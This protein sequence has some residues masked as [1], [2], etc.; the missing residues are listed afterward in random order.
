MC[1]FIYTAALLL[2]TTAA[3]AQSERGQLRVQVQDSTGAAVPAAI[4]L[5]SDVNHIERTGVAN[6]SGEFTSHNLPFGI[7]RLTVSHSGFAAA[8]RLIEIHSEPVMSVA[9]TLGVAPVTSAVVVND[10]ATLVDPSRTSTTYTVGRQAVNQSL[11]AQPG[12][13]LTDL[14]NDQPGW[15]YEANGVLHP[16]GAEYGVQYVVDGMPITENR[17][18]AFAPPLEADE[19]ESLRVRTAGYPAE[20]GRKLG[21]IVEVTTPP[22]LPAGFH[23]KAAVSGGSFG[24]AAGFAGLS[25]G[26]GKNQF[27]FS[28][29]RGTTDR[30]LDPP[31]VANFTN[32]GDFG[33]VSASYSQDLSGRDRVRFSFT[34]GSANFQVPNELVQQQVGQRQQ[35]RNSDISGIVA[36][37]RIVTDNLLLSAEASVRDSAAR[38]SSNP[39]STPVIADQQ[40]GYREGYARV[41]LAG[42]SGRHDWKL[43]ADGVFSNVHEALQYAVTDPSQ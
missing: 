40:R 24:S 11:A 15:V 12:R 31:V 39:L 38:L 23:G 17:S 4:A 29:D 9:I 36:Y 19:A 22:D 2:A 28:G 25:Y 6:N 7:Y 41:D 14:I 18:P 20:Y 3:V 34:H 35:R 32:H 13:S 43:G 26:K 30:Y 10:A 37:Q 8:D 33:G 42:H 16:R 1:R 5:I 21:G 27:T